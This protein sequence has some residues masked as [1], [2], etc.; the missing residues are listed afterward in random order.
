MAEAQGEAG[1]QVTIFQCD[2]CLL[3]VR[4]VKKMDDGTEICWECASE[5]RELA[6]IKQRRSEEIDLSSF[7]A[8]KKGLGN[9]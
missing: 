4:L 8:T 7:E 1:H 9:E 6:R 2:D 5:R 3:T